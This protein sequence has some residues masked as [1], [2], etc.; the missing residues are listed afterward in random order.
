[1]GAHRAADLHR[2]QRITELRDGALRELDAA[3]CTE[4]VPYCSTLF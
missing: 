1:M 4:R 2:A 3:F